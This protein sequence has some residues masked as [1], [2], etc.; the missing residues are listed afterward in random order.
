MQANTLHDLLAAILPA[1]ERE[2]LIRRG[3][4]PERWSLLFGL[5]EVFA[6]VPLLISNA[7]TSFQAI[8]NETAAYLVEHVRPEDFEKAKGAV[9]SSG[10]LIWLAWAL[11]PT[12]W[13]LASI[14]LTGVARLVS[15]GVSRGAFWEPRG[16]ANF[17]LAA[18][19]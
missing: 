15:F 9:I 19:L 5:V 4:V 10:P 3:A 12:T 6:G 14:C 1:P 18:T 11:R 7:L 8:A 17:P 2:E 13:L 16:L